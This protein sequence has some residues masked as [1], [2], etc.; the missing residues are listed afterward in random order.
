[1]CTA[2]VLVCRVIDIPHPQ[3]MSFPRRSKMHLGVRESML[4]FLWTCN[5]GSPTAW[6]WVYSRDY[7][8]QNPH[9]ITLDL[10]PCPSVHE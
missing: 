7:K 6:R 2:D 10:Y 4:I 3:L 1:M 9:Q 5:L 8:E